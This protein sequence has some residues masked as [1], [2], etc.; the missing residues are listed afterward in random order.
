MGKPAIRGNTYRRWTGEICWGKAGH[1]SRFSTV[2]PIFRE[3]QVRLAYASE[4]LQRAG[5]STHDSM[6]FLADNNFPRPAVRAIQEHGFEV[7]RATED[8]PGSAGEEVLARCANDELTVRTLDKDF[9][10]LM[11]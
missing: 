4:V 11:F 8:N 7:A 2:I 3:I 9:G 6:M 5:L 1:R 10:E